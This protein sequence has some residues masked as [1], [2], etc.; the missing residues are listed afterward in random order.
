MMSIVNTSF[1]STYAEFGS[2]IDISESNKGISA[3]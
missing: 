1:I 3:L 2:V